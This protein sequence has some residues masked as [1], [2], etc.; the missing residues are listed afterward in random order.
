LKIAEKIAEKKN[1]KINFDLEKT[2]LNE[3]VAKTP[4]SDPF[5]VK[6][7][8]KICLGALLTQKR[9]FSTFSAISRVRAPFHGPTLTISKNPSGSKLVL[10]LCQRLYGK[11]QKVSC[12]SQDSLWSYSRLKCWWA[13]IAPPMRNRVNINRKVQANLVGGSSF[14]GRLLGFLKLEFWFIYLDGKVQVPWRSNPV[15]FKKILETFLIGHDCG[16]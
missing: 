14:K 11:S 10:K 9:R 12:H 7:A 13:I 16:K 2:L 15:L 5:L 1:Q 4:K 8:K 6:S 3:K